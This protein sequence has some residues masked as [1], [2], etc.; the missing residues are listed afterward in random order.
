MKQ[1]HIPL[2]GI[3]QNI[4]LFGFDPQAGIVKLINAERDPE[5]S[6]LEFDSRA[7][8]KNSLYFALPGLH[9]DGH[10]FIDKAI[11]NG[12]SAIVFQNELSRYNL[13]YRKDVAYIQVKDSRF[14]MSPIAAAFY[15]NPSERICCIGVTGTEGKSTTV[16]LVFQLLRALGQKAGFISTVEFSVDGAENKN[17]EHQTTPEATII[18]R[19]LCEMLENSCA[20]AVLECSSHGLSPLTNRL[21]NVLFDAAIM[22]NVTREHLEFHKTFEQYRFDKANLFRGLRPKSGKVPFGVV[23]ACD[24]SAEYFKNATEYPVY[25]FAACAA[26]CLPQPLL[27]L[28]SIRPASGGNEYEVFDSETKETYTIKDNLPGAFNA[29]NVMAALITVSKLLKIS[30]KELIPAVA[31]LRPVH[32]RM[33]T[34]DCGQDFEILVDYAH[35][36]SSF[37]TIFPPIRGRLP[38]GA[39]I[40]AVFGS[41]GERD[42]EKRSRQGKIASQWADIVILTDEDPRG[43]DPLAI[44][45]EIASGV[46]GKIRGETLF[47]I[48]DRPEAVKKAI[49][50]AKKRDIVLLLGK[51]HE[52][53]IIYSRG[54]KTTIPYDEVECAKAALAIRPEP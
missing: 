47:L 45:E 36:P 17:P 37:E 16:Y 27:A 25:S 40:I 49:S 7:V 38:A 4:A 41:A 3:L 15:S 39:K 8:K 43:E 12:A 51:G 32:G 18:Q 29:N 34:V 13:D 42:T 23:N 19:R 11:G 10:S 33:T 46:E 9:A 44:L 22:A 5:I 54:G 52:N 14:A 53:T 35:T 50:L 26:P 21:G 20:F 48:P 1:I 24:P 28:K 2:S 31:G 30:I 6:S